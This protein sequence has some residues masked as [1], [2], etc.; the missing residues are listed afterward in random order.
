MLIR[1]TGRLAFALVPWIA[2]LFLWIPIL[3]L[4]LFSFNDSRM[5]AVW[6]GF[7][8]HWYQGLL[9]GQFGDQPNFTT[10]NLL[11]ALQRSLFVGAVSTA[12]ATVLGTMVA[13]GLERYRVRGK[14][15]IEMLMYLPVVI[16]EITMGLSLLIYFSSGFNVLRQWFGVQW[17]LSL[18][19]VIIGH[20]VFSLPFVAIAVRARLS[21]MTRSLEEAA[22]DL[23]ANEWRT[24]QRITLPLLMPGI[25]AGALLAF[26]LSL[27]DFVITF[28]TQGPGTTTLPLFVYGMIKFQVTPDI[29]AISTLMVLA[30]IAL[31]TCSL[32]IQR[33]RT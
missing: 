25:L 17:T 11:D 10:A 16:P 18:W 4:I 15:L 13:L 27:D 5:S 21:G 9:A 14:R 22:R 2:Y 26:T 19:T 6:R 28:F 33:N 32:L 31:V 20:V 1:R 29:N 3:V 7:T 23:G 8:F 24:F 30:S 12:I